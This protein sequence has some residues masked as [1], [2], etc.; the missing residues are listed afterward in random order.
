MTVRHQS[1]NFV[2]VIKELRPVISWTQSIIAFN[3]YTEPYYGT[4]SLVVVI[5]QVKF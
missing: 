3:W 2:L 4:V 5:G 1:A